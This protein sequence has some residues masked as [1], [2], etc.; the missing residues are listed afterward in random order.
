MKKIYFLIFLIYLIVSIYFLRKQISLEYEWMVIMKDFSNYG[1]EYRLYGK[2]TAYMPPFYSYFL[3]I[4][5]KIFGSNWLEIV[6]FIQGLV[7]FFSLFSLFKTLF[8]EKITSIIVIAG[9]CSIL[10]FPPLLI[11]IYK[12]SSFAFSLSSMLLFFSVIYR[13]SVSKSI[14]NKQ[15]LSIVLICT[16]SLYLRYEFIFIIILSVIAFYISKRISLK[17]AISF[18]LVASLIYLPWCIRN[19]YKI[20]TFAYSTS[21]N[22]N[23][24]K[25]YS[26]KYDPYITFNNP[27]SSK[28]KLT[29]SNTTLSKMFTNEKDMNEYLHNL[30]MEFVENNPKLFV[31][32][33]VIKFLINLTQYFPGYEGLNRNKV[34]LFY[35]LY[36]IFI[37]ILLIISLK[38][39]YLQN[40]RSFLVYITGGLYLFFLFF[41][42]IAPLP[43]YMLL[44]YPIFI[45]V[46]LK[47]NY[48]KLQIGKYLQNT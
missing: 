21:F 4:S 28:L 10:F 38:K 23:F 47:A 20:G 45:A 13:I 46:I 42:V 33:T 16:I 40:K 11:G 6:C 26:E 29:L 17:N 35:S 18:L 19:Y 14:S 43:R 8:K 2:Y 7:I 3:L 1:W 39:L 37:Q 15:W 36:S 34:Y 9:F 24:A 27:Y 12:V 48:G 41:Y 44:Y 32:Q 25:G 30:N 5:S 22:F 31:K